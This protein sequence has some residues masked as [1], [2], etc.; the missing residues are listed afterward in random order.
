MKRQNILIVSMVLA[1]TLLVA[2][3]FAGT[4]SNTG[5]EVFKEVLRNHKSE[6]STSGTVTATVEFL[7]NNQSVAM[8]SGVITGD[9]RKEA[10]SGDL[11][12]IADGLEKDLFLLGANGEMFIHDVATNDVY[13]T[14][15]DDEDSHEFDDDDHDHTFTKEEEA[16][17]DYFVGD[18]ANEFEVENLDDDT[19]NISLE[20]TQS[21]M[22]EIINL[23]TSLDSD[24]DHKSDSKHDEKL[25]KELNSDTYPLFKELCE[26]DIEH[27][28]LVD[29]IEVNYFKI[30][31]NVDSND[32][33][34]GMSVIVKVSGVDENNEKHNLTYKSNMTFSEVDES[35]VIGLDLS[36]KNIIELPEFDDEN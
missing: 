8:V 20:L 14:E 22:P 5:Y 4:A 31:L 9:E 2:T 18:L 11:K 36:D 15:L 12:I 26:L 3:A 13:R 27:T 29:D 32:Q 17:F 16:V 1:M 35:A 21:E 24:D 30:V 10:F 6:T 34:V 28:E 7:D 25:F 23:L 33:I 19:Y